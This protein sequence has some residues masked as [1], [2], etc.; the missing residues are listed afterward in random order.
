M[1]NYT[2]E[3]WVPRGK[4]PLVKIEARND[5]SAWAK[6]VRWLRSGDWSGGEDGAI[7]LDLCRD[8]KVI[9]HEDVTV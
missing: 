4:S 1:K 7:G 8:G 6:A 5:K 3:H 9:R 2:A